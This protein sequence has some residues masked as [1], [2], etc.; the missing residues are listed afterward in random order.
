[1]RQVVG[2]H[3]LKHDGGRH[4]RLDQRHVEGHEVLD[5]NDGVLRVG[6]RYAR[7]R[8][9]VPDRKVLDPLAHGVHLAR[10]FQP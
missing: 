5:G 9:V 4:P 2:G 1:M 3:A 10:A 6:A 8:Y 7:V